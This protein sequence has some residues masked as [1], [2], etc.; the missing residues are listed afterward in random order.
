MHDPQLAS[1]ALTELPADIATSP[2]FNADLA[3]VP[4]GRRNWS[5]YNFAALWISM[6][7]CIPTYM[8][9]GGLIAVGM[10][11]WQALLTIALGN[12]I[13]L[14]PILL[15]AHPGTRYGIPFPVFARA[16]FGT[17]GANLPAVLRAIVACGWFGIQCSIGG[18]AIKTFF[19]ALWPSF[20]EFGGDTSILGLSCSSAITF[21]IF[22]LL[23]IW[24]IYRGMNAVRV[25]ENWAAPIV[26]VLALALLVWTVDRAHG[27]GPMLTAESKFKTL[28]AFWSEFI[29]GLTAMIGFW[30]TLSLNIPDFTRFGRGQKEQMLG[31]TL[32]LPTTMLVFSAMGVIVTSA[33]QAILRGVAIDKLWDPVFILSQIVSPAAPAGLDAPL[34]ASAG[35]RMFVAVIA[36]FG[37]GV[38][39]LS[40]NIAA[41]VVSPANDF[42]NL[43]PRAISFK[44]GGLITGV[45]G[46]A[47]MPWKLL[48]SPTTYI[49][50]W[51]VGYSALLGPIAGIMIVDYWVLRRRE[52]DVP[53]LYR[54][55]GRYAGVNRSAV[56]ALVLGVL[57]NVPGFL[58][59]THVIEGDP[60]FFDT[61]YNY[62]WFVG[63]GIAGALYGALEAPRRARVR[64]NAPRSASVE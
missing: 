35:V 57:P 6:A 56:I 54:P 21:A 12:S 27:L 14:A 33:S 58:K 11:W 26:L 15:N 49:F 30:A 40:V 46:I 28:S 41:N 39:T 18:E 42:A 3:P 44:T 64:S 51:L 34:I 47:M 37:V 61:L 23:N 55:N 8:L 50:Q 19:T 43:A 31:Q 7:H 38:A 10:N 24:I 60:T 4:K 13:V 36:L 59:V 1:E 9:A 53:D 45:L 16:A 52:L 32:G 22:W 2:L 20:G 48:A 63:F 5:T 29:P 62:A 25:F 17:R